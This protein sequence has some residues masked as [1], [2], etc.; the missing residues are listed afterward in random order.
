[1][2]DAV[3]DKPKGRAERIIDSVFARWLARGAMI[4]MPIVVTVTIGLAT[5]YLDDKFKSQADATAS[6]KEETV[7]LTSR[8]DQQAVTIGALE[9]RTTAIE[10]STRL[11]RQDREAFQDQTTQDLK[12]IDD[13]LGILAVTVA[14][15]NAK[16][17]I[18]GQ[19]QA[20]I[21]PLRPGNATPPLGYRP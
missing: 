16:L 15:V 5:R 11:G 2:T 21:A 17:E 14:A 12:E 6:V 8:L 20:S 3:D 1:M 7:K 9:N 19:R 10:T 18:L 4:L 13:K